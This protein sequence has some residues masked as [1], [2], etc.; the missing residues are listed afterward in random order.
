M[1]GVIVARTEITRRTILTIDDS[2]GAT[3]DI[4]VNQ[5]DPKEKLTTENAQV[6]YP[7]AS[8]ASANT[9][10]NAN[11]NANSTAFNLPNTSTET[12]DMQ[13][14]LQV[15]HVSFTDRTIIDISKLLPG[16]MIKAKGTVNTFRSVMQMNLERFEIIRDTNAEMRFI[17]ERLRFFVE[18]LSIPWELTD[19]EIETLR[20]QALEMDLKTV[21][22]RKRDEKKLRYGVER[23]EKDQRH[24]LRQYEREEKKRA[25]SAGVSKEAGAKA[26]HDIRK[27]RVFSGRVD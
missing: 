12:D 16:T 20:H 3:L 22:R 9:N 21:E 4:I 6:S 2:S 11:S 17:D 23:E 14:L 26:M 5:A 19:E 24:I 10:A 27:K 15:I 25:K 7:T 13:T 18:V 1:V 8:S